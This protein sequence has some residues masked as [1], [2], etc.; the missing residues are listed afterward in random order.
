MQQQPRL[1]AIQDSPP[2]EEEVVV[3]RVAARR[4][5]VVPAVVEV[6]GAEGEELRALRQV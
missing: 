2:A 5:S 3:E 1:A 4:L 6:G